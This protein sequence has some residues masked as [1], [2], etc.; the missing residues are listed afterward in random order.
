MSRPCLFKKT[1]CP[2]ISSKPTIFLTIMAPV[3]IS[4][5]SFTS[6]VDE[7]G[8]C[9]EAF[10]AAKNLDTGVCAWGEWFEHLFAKGMFVCIGISGSTDI[11]FVD[12]ENAHRVNARG[13]EFDDLYRF[14]SSPAPDADTGAST[15]TSLVPTPSS[16]SANNTT[17]EQ[18]ANVALSESLQ[19]T[20]PSS[21]ATNAPTTNASTAS[22]DI[23]TSHVTAP[24]PLNTESIT[25]P[26]TSTTDVGDDSVQL[27]HP[28]AENTGTRDDVVPD[29]PAAVGAAVQD[30]DDTQPHA[31]GTPA[32]TPS[33]PPSQSVATAGATVH[34]DDD[35]QPPAKDTPTP[36]P[37]PPPTPRP[38][39]NLKRK[40]DNPPPTGVD[41]SKRKRPA[42]SVTTAP[43][44]RKSSRR[45]DPQT[46][47]AETRSL[48]SKK[49]PDQ[50]KGGDGPQ[51]R[52]AR[53]GGK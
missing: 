31:D 32:P 41:S 53:K 25:A 34:D 52:S 36:T 9:F 15:S 3:L 26:A 16:L 5:F 30:D 42:N 24:S 50:P 12:V 18:N 10:S 49:S 19:P 8:Q 39:R 45:T 40:I 1:A 37:S 46:T 23:S 6:G 44:T 4:V 48:R 21:T 35:M 2:L 38:T 51:R 20:E 27:V 7:D 14:E 29:G 13:D 22:D 11:S 47:V 28:A 17:N 43:T 33:L